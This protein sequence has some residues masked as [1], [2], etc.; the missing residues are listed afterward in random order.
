MGATFDNQFDD[1]DDDKESWE[2]DTDFDVLA[3]DFKHRYDDDHLR[4]Y[5]SSIKRDEYTTN[6]EY[7][8]AIDDQALCMASTYDL[9]KELDRRFDQVAIFGKRKLVSRPVIRQ[10]GVSD[11][12]TN[13]LPLDRS[14]VEPGIE[15]IDNR[16]FL[17]GDTHTLHGMATELA[18]HAHYSM[19]EGVSY[20]KY[21][22]GPEA[23][24][25]DRNGIDN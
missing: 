3:Q 8:E 19:G 21:G 13:P 12:D 1:D 10:T 17:R 9:I 25:Y 2:G 23:E 24:T 20:I 22:Y 6:A 7:Q 18:E 5:E 15:V 11:S 16:F 14:N 4:F